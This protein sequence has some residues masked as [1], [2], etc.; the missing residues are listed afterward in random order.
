MR[1]EKRIAA[2][3]ICDLNVH[4]G[5]TPILWDITLQVPAGSLVGI[6]GPNGAG[7]STL[8]KTILGMVPSSSGTIQLL[9]KPLENMRKHIAHIPQREC[10]D[11]EFPITLRK[12]V[13]MGAYPKR[14]LFG[15][16]LPEDIAAVETAIEMLGLISVADRQISALSGGQQQR[17]FLARALVQDADLYFLD[18]PF[19]GV[20]H[21]SE[22]IIVDTLKAM[23]LEQKTIFVVH[24][25]LVTAEK[26]FDW[27]ILLN[28]RLVA[29]GRIKEVF[30]LDNLR[31][32]Y[33]QN[34]SLIEEVVKLAFQM[35]RGSE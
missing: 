20:D 21:T 5:S 14:G 16:L 17:A 13:E 1:D 34:V 24:H 12:L 26:Y 29:S 18:E 23:R 8:V 27:L 15:K 2:L 7:K 10:V 11:W 30:T 32:A 9:G 33:G 22:R 19:S 3:D 31:L 28:T 4:Y 6:M 25:D 35:Q